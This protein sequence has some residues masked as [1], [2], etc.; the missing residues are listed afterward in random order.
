MRVSRRRFLGVGASLAAWAV[1]DIAPARADTP[2]AAP[3][4]T[5]PTWSPPRI[6]IGTPAAGTEPGLVF[7]APT[8]TGASSVPPGQFGPTILDNDG[9]PVWFLPLQNELAQNFRVQTWHDRPVL[10]W[11]EGPTGSTY[12]GSCV[13]YSPA[14]RELK[15]VHGGNGYSCDLHEF[16]L[17]E[18]GTALISIYNEV[19]ANLS[20]VGGPSSGSVVEGIVQELD[21]ATGEV[22]FEWH[23]LDHVAV[24]E[25]Y[26]TAPSSAGDVDYF[27]LNSIGVDTDDNLLVSARH[28][29]TVYKL[30]RK[31]GKILWR[32]GGMNSD[33]QLGP[34]AAF[35]FQHDARA[36]DDGT[37]TL[38][39]N[40]ATGEGGGRRRAGLPPAPAA[41]RRERDDGGAGAGLPG[42]RAAPCDRSRQ[43]AAAAARRGV[44]RVGPGGRVLRAHAGRGARLRRDLPRFDLVLPRLPLPVGRE[45]RDEPGCRGVRPR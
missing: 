17:T 16:L 6:T 12:G 26:R 2:A 1:L 15:R 28:T 35:H 13:I 8:P 30:D 19:A 29:S 45:P 25:S 22:V 41:S 31:S 23:S 34:G 24:A 44:R 38:F 21:V 7:V 10:T 43:R 40:G 39:D 37:L 4:S 42:A 27:H 20:S 18:R 32:L 3:Y 33:F 9:E 5:Q 36:H 11:Y 14:Y